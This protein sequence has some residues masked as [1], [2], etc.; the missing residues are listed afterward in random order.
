MR[1][2]PI[3]LYNCLLHLLYL[4]NKY[5]LSAYNMLNTLPLEITKEQIDLF[6]LS[7]IYEVFI[8]LLA[9]QAIF[10]SLSPNTD[11][12]YLFFWYHCIDLDLQCNSE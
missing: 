4:F 7:S 9:F 2:F 11:I 8:D 1:F 5:L 3:I 6:F 10:L 12:S